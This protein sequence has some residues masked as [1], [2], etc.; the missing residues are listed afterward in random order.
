M[1][2]G[3]FLHTGRDP[4]ET[5]LAAIE[6]HARLGLRHPPFAELADEGIA[7][8]RAALDRPGPAPKTPGTF[9]GDPRGMLIAELLVLTPLAREILRHK[10][11]A[12]RTFARGLAL[13]D[14][15]PRWHAD[16]VDAARGEVEA[17]NA[18][19]MEVARG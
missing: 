4:I 2:S 9:W 12:L 1:D 10:P 7:L 18:S 8:L 11:A 16:A 14:E 3:L 17:F 5:L 15:A 19:V 6:L 13:I